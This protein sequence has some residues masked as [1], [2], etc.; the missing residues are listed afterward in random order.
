[1]DQK[2]GREKEGGEMQLTKE[3]AQLVLRLLGLFEQVWKNP[4][5]PWC[6]CGVCETAKRA[7]KCHYRVF[8]SL[9]KKAEAV[10]N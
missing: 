2:T 9:T 1:M 5:R 4:H 6:E 7:G 8:D 3:E 10:C